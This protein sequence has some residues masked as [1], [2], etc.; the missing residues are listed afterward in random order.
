MSYILD[1]LR[2]ADAERERG[3]V[4]GLHTQQFGV[5]PGDNEAPR[6]PKLLIA[7]T[8][9]LAL[10]LAGVLVWNFSGSDSPPK[11]V[12]VVQAPIAPATLP[13]LPAAS[14][15]TVMP[16]P[17][18]SPAGAPRET[19]AR[20]APIKPPARRDDADATPSVP[21]GDRVY[22]QAELPEAIRRGLPKIVF[23]GASYSGDKASRMVILNGQVFHEGDTVAPELVLKQVKQKGAVLAYKGYP[24]ELGF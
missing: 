9:V 17:V 20:R 19:T 6:K 2:R 5:L 3:E 13:P 10:A 12:I 7:A 16:A 15:A 4:P 14:Q 11:T 18:P 24:Y 22:I 21:A 1:A 8:V 23:G